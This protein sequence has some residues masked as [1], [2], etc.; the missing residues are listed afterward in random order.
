MD[1]SFFSVEN[2]KK[3]QFLRN[4]P[5]MV[6]FLIM[7]IMG[8]SEEPIGAWSLQIILEERGIHLSTA[9]IGRYLKE[10]DS[11][12][13]TIQFSN[14]GR[15]LTS[16]EQEALKVEEEL[17]VSDVLHSNMRDA[18]EVRHYSDLID[19]YVVR[20]AIE[21]EAVRLCVKNITD[22]EL[23]LLREDVKIY[24]EYVADDANFIEPALEFHAIISLATKNKFMD[25]L[26]Q[27]LLYE[28]KKIE[29]KMQI[30]VT[31]EYGEKYVEEHE[32][33]YEAIKARDEKLAMKLMTQHFDGMIEVLSKQ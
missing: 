28:Q 24:K 21:V 10:L 18:V 25:S 20:K 30:V 33:I 22:E 11:K 13:Y 26:T 4:Q 32:M 1:I 15:I 2:M 8:D 29:Q 3:C 6:H 23:E 19:I 16:K 14:K 27:M 31:Q 5:E 12:G 7:K 9:T 17:A